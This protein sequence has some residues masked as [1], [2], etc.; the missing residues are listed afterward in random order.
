MSESRYHSLN[1][2][3]HENA[4]SLKNENTWVTESFIQQ[5]NSQPLIHSGTKRHCFTQTRNGSV[6]GLFGTIFFGS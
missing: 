6:V 4:D 5:N 2:L 1:W 3:V